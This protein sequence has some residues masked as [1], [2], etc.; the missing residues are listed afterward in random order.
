MNAAE[1]TALATGI[2]SILTAITA[3]IWA[4]RGKQAAIV[5]QGIA[6]HANNTMNAHL[7]TMHNAFPIQPPTETNA[8]EH[9]MPEEPGQ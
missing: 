8:V 6:A 2:P 1:I 9:M 5:A 3:V 4:I 7:T